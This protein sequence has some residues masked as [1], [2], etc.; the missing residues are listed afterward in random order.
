MVIAL[1]ASSLSAAGVAHATS[2][3]AMDLRAL[4]HDADHV[5]VG[6]VV[7]Q[8]ARYD[9]LDRIVTDVTIR[10][11]E[12]MHGAARE[13]TTIVVRRLGGVIGDVGLR[14]E[15][16]PSFV[17]G[18]R[19][20]LFARLVAADHV[21]RPIG[22][23]Q[24]VLPISRESGIEMVMPG[25]EGLALVQRGSDGRLR[26]APGA[27]MAPEPVDALLARVRDL[28]AEIHGAD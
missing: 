5:V 1:V 2:T 19:V 25:G 4:V 15:G 28:V 23:S 7:S 26:A 9:H 22:M 16:E 10:V 12:R 21:L 17:E 24:G 3:E 20:V 11:D 14:I 13:G 6:T 18:E 27:L 8:D